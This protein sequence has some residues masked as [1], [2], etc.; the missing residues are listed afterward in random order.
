MSDS[1]ISGSLN[2]GS[3]LIYDTILSD[4][5]GQITVFN[6]NNKDI[7]FAISGANSFLYYDASSDRLGIGD[8]IP[9]ATLHIVAPCS[10]DGLKIEGTTNC[11]TGVRIFLLHN[12]GTASQ[13]GDY[14]ASL[15]FA[16]RDSNGSTIYYGQIRS[17]ILDPVTSQTSGELIFNVDNTGTLSTVFRASSRNSVLGGLNNIDGS[18]YSSFGSSNTLSGYLFVNVGSY[19]SG[20][21]VTGILLGN[22]CLV[23][24]SNISIISNKADIIGSNIVLLGNDSTISGDNNILLANNSFVS[25]SDNNIFGNN[26]R[27]NNGSSNTISLANTGHISGLYNINI[28]SKVNISGS[29]NLSIGNFNNILG[30]TNSILGSYISTTGSDNLAYGNNVNISG[31]QVISVGNSNSF[32][33]GN[34]GLIIGNNI[35]IPDTSKSMVIGLDNSIENS[36]SSGIVIGI[37][38][39][40]SGGSSTNLVMLGQNNISTTISNSL[41]VGNKNN[42]SGT[43]NNN[44]ILGPDNYSSVTSNNNLIVG[45]LNNTTGSFIFSDGSLS[46]V[47]YRAS[48][49]INNSTIFGIQNVINR[50]L[51]IS[52][53]GNKN[54][55]SG[56][57]LNSFGSFNSIKNTNN[58]QNFGNNNFI[59]GNNI[60][61]FGSSGNVVGFSSIVNTPS[62][63]NTYAF[64]S[65]NILFGDNEIVLNGLCVGFENDLYGINN[66]VY[67]KNNKLGLQRLI[68]TTTDNQNIITYGNNTTYFNPGDRVVLG[69]LNPANTTNGGIYFAQI[70]TDE[71]AI[72]YD[73]ING[74][75]TTI[76][77]SAALSSVTGTQYSSKNS[78]DQDFVLAPVV[79][80]WI[81]PYQ[82]GNDLDDL[83]N[84]PLYGTENI[85]LGNNNKYLNLSGLI[86][87]KN[88]NIT[89]INNIIIG[90]GITGYYNNSLQIGTDNFSKIYLDYNSIIFNSEAY[91]NEAIFVSRSGP[92]TL[93]ADLANNRVGINVNNPRS[94][95]DVSGVLT[96]NS[97]RVGLSGIAGYSLISDSDGNATWQ[98]PVNLSGTN[99]GILYKIN[100][101]V[102]SGINELR[103]NSGTKSIGYARPG[104]VGLEL[105]E[106]ISI[107]PDHIYLNKVDTDD[108]TIYN[109]TIYGSGVGSQDD[110]TQDNGVRIRLL[111]TLPQFNAIQVYNITG[112]SG[113]LSRLTV[114]D[115]LYVPTSLTGT[116]LSIR[117]SDGF[118]TGITNP[119]NT[120]LF[121]NR[122]SLASGNNN[123]KFF[124]NDQVLTVGS[125]GTLTENQVLNFNGLSDTQYNIILASTS[126]F[127]TVINNAGRNQPFSIIDAGRQNVNDRLG[128][129]YYTNSGILGIGVLPTDTMQSTNGGN[130][131][132]WYSL[133][134]K[135]VVKGKIKTNALQITPNDGFPSSSSARYLRADD[136]GNVNLSAIS[137]NTQFSGV[138]PLYANADIAERV[139][140]GL[141]NSLPGGGAYGATQNG[142][143]LSFNGNQWTNNTK[144]VRFVQPD[145]SVNDMDA[146]PGSLFGPGGKLNSCRNNHV[147]AGSPFM[148]NGNNENGSY[149]GSSQ[150]SRFY[151]KGRTVNTSS[152]E[153]LSNFTK[154]IVSSPDATNT[155]SVQYTNDYGSQNNE[156]KNCVWLYEIKYCGLISRKINSSETTPLTLEGVAGSLRGAYLI[157]K[158]ISDVTNMIPLGSGI[159]EVFTNQSSAN[160]SWIPVYVTGIST[161]NVQRLGVMANGLQDRNILWNTTIDIQQIN[162]PSGINGSAIFV[163][164]SI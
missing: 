23:S 39:N 57:N 13:T 36:L 114:K 76:N 17:R 41:V 162:M 136:D 20:Y 32:I 35:N 38:N 48:D 82:N 150:L 143:I 142:L 108:T 77:L 91:Q 61:M 85:V 140:I 145:F 51:N 46:G 154:D 42:I 1:V 28:G 78:F 59:A 12:P 164:G 44:I 127:G 90:N 19:N 64:G 63:R 101:K 97:L 107:T 49:S 34:S 106:V 40:I 135:L 74:N 139:D 30:N 102:A 104:T 117:S 52:I 109:M 129:H 157:Y 148:E 55:V 65:G 134:A 156:V 24:G 45:V 153:L 152:T 98:F 53:L 118:V 7:D 37:T 66:I 54:W 5:S 103:F 88:N 73:N 158:D 112:V 2:I 72:V 123:L 147:F 29:N 21:L 27:I 159:N 155:I 6:Q 60:N 81:I 14:P 80:G 15:D 11:P 47:S 96:T 58:I 113:H 84:E 9:D 22:N 71:N 110:I 149:Q 70:N 31:S 137:L 131:I 120:L 115:Y 93:K 25:G 138:W 43:V 92:N 151:L 4:K 133:P 8:K 105:D 67:G 99:N 122:S 141:S 16:G 128:L 125:T 50:G 62:L 130:A 126:S 89:G 132:P 33:N 69:I 161:E 86:L 26:I 121:A 124:A 146:I 79:S 18:S 116:F 83:L 87:G 111:T 68:F 160:N 119:G 10:N 3:G 75:I 94:T 100:D 95:L 163:N 144:G 56:N